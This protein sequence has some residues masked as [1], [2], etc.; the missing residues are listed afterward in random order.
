MR[1]ARRDWSSVALVEGGEASYGIRPLE[2]RVDQGDR[3]SLVPGHEVSV[4][5]EGDLDGQSA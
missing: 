3:F 5:I 2:I 1:T 4:E